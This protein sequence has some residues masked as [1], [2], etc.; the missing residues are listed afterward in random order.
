MSKIQLTYTIE[1]RGTGQV[2]IDSLGYVCGIHAT[3]ADAQKALPHVKA[4]LNR[5]FVHAWTLKKPFQQQNRKQ[6][7]QV[8][9]NKYTPKGK[10]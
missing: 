2:I 1:Q 7:G 6:N 9:K 4:N 10:K 5:G 8:S 3:V